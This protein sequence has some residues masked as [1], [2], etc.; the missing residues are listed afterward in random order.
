MDCD[1]VQLEYRDKIDNKTKTILL[2]D[3][4][5][6]GDPNYNLPN[7]TNPLKVEATG[8]ANEQ[9]AWNRAQ[10]ELNRII[11]KRVTVETSVTEE[12]ILLPLNA[13]ID[14]V[15]GTTL[16]RVQSNGEI[17]SYD[18]L[19]IITSEECIFE[20][21]KSYSVILRNDIGEPD[22]PIGVTERSD[23]KFGFVLDLL[24]QSALFIRGDNDFQVGMLYNFAPDGD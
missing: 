4:L 20:E 24:P 7:T 19:N 18:G 9:Q 17:L 5:E 21:G 1:G 11:H 23:S 6:V 15:D 2:P 10:Y 13:R 14:H 8:V 12:G 16:S 3:D 22:L